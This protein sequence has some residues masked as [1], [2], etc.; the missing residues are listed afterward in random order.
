VLLEAMACAVPVVASKI[1]ASR[2]A[3]REGKLGTLVDPRNASEIKAAIIEGLSR[4][5]DRTRPVPGVEYFSVERFEERVHAITRSIRY[6][7]AANEIGG[8]AAV[9]WMRAKANDERLE[10]VLS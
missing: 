3:L 6:G 5:G 8:D 2:E 1:D 7:S 9:D 10:E 4:A